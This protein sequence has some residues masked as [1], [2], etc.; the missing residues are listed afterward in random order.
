MGHKDTNKI[1]NQQTS[2][3]LSSVHKKSIELSYSGEK[4]SSDGGLLLLKEVEN[5]I[6]IVRNFSACINDQRDQ[7]YIEHTIESIVSQ[8]VFQIASG[9]EDANDCNMLRSDAVIKLCSNQLPETGLDLSSQPTMSRF[10]NSVRRSELYQIAKMFVLNFI[11]SYESE[12]PVIIID[13]DDT[14]HTAYG[15][16]L[17]IEFN[18]Y[19]GD[20]VF[21]PLHIYEGLSGKLITTILKPGR[22]SKSVN[23]FAVLKRIIQLLRTYWKNTII[24]VRGDSHFHCPELTSYSKIDKKIILITG[25]TGNSCLNKLAGTTITSAKKKF[26]IT[27]EPVKMYHTFAYKAGSWEEEERV[28][29]KVEVNSLG[30]NIRYIATNSWEFRTKQMYEMGYCARGAMELRIKDHKTYLK[31]DRSSCHKFEA[32]QLRLFLHSVAYVLIHTLQ[33]EVLRG[34][35]FAN[36]TMQ[37]IQLKILKTAARVKEL[38]TKIKIEFPRTCPAR[39]IQTKAFNILEVLRC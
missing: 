6:N 32:N 37:T 39:D 23:V 7:R 29:V 30:T 22:R 3:N 25:L 4:I 27:K 16:Q 35:E 2:L 19:Y 17:Q 33:K 13:P 12:P 18:N 26:E 20:Y 24:I 9:Y 38:K 14:N 5:Q 31:S 34:T 10:E 11:N 28:I 36:A 21:M 15:N 8:R 1:D